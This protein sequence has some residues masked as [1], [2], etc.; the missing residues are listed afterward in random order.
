MCGIIGIVG[1]QDVASLLVNSLMRLEYRGY[2]SCGVAT[3]SSTGI[4]VRKDVGPV[5]EIAD[6][7]ALALAP[8]GVGIA[9]TRW[10][11]HGGVSR[12][13]S[14]PHLSC[15]RA[16]AVVHNGI[17]SNYHE[18]KAELQQCGHTFS[19]QTD[20]EVVAHLLEETYHPERS[21]EEAFVDALHR[22][23]GSF[24]IAMIS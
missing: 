19:S 16:F 4:E 9:H 13:S 11:T 6:R 17:I 7:C 20:T 2:D 1:K 5:S 15:D 23:Q 3:L 14:H 10:A 22:I 12:E 8:G 21:V 24:A 18:F